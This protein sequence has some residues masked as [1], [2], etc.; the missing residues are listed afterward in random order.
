MRAS[1]L[2]LDRACRMAWERLDVALQRVGSV[3]RFR[4]PLW[5]RAI[6]CCALAASRYVRPATTTPCGVFFERG[7]TSASGPP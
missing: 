7:K 5:R 3:V 6:T 1:L 2:Q 4:F